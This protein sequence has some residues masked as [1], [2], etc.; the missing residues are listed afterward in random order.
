VLLF[1]T[2]T[3]FQVTLENHIWN[4][5]EP[6]TCNIHQENHLRHP[7]FFSGCNMIYPPVVKRGNAAMIQWNTPNLNV[8]GGGFSPP[9]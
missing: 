8:T 6:A 5:M 2:L 4:I 3:H 9:L 1:I 7:D